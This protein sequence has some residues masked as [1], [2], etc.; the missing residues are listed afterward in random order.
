MPNVEVGIRVFLPDIPC[1]DR[2]PRCAAIEGA[3]D[4]ILT[5]Y[6][7]DG[8]LDDD[9]ASRPQGTEEEEKRHLALLRKFW[10]QIRVPDVSDP[11]CD[12]YFEWRKG[13]LKQGTGERTT[14]RTWYYSFSGHR[15]FVT[16]LGSAWISIRLRQRIGSVAM[17]AP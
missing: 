14:D 6:E 15:T 12:N 4:D 1:V 3:T 2:G 7:R 16:R 10:S 5:R 9:L 11:V 8:Y 17:R 13:K